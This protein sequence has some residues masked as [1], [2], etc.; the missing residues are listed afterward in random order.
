VLSCDKT[1]KRP[2]SMV[3]GVS[4]GGAFDRR[5]ARLL[6]KSDSVMI[7]FPIFQPGGEVLAW[8]SPNDGLT[9]LVYPL[10][11]HGQKLAGRTSTL[12]QRVS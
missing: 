12:A 3:A 6:S 9:V 11:I 10:R 1:L 7:N 4:N 5:V 2:N 8:Q